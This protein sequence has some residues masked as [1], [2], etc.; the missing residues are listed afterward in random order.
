MLNEEI[1]AHMY[2]LIQWCVGHGTH[3]A[4]SRDRPRVF[5]AKRSE[6]QAAGGDA[7][8]EGSG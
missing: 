6:P 8:G 5:V 7:E 1:H 3:L 2:F 4:C